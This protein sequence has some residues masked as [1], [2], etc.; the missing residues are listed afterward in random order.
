MYIK[1]LLYI[2]VYIYIHLYTCIYVLEI[3]QALGGY[4]NSEDDSKFELFLKS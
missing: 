3:F 2:H 1:Y 4:R